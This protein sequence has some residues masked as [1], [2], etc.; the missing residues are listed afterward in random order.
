MTSHI[1]TT[2]N[3]QRKILDLEGLSEWKVE[4]GEAYCWRDIKI[5][6]IPLACTDALFLHEVAHAIYPYAE[7]D[8]LNHY[9]GAQWALKFERLVSKYLIRRDLTNASLTSNTQEHPAP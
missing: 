9:H 3:W 8:Q 7:G 2:A 4:E 1:L 5:I 6:K